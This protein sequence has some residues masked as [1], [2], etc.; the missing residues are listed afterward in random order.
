LI[1]RNG[2]EISRNS[3]S[4][5]AQLD[6]SGY[7]VSLYNQEHHQHNAQAMVT[8]LAAAAITTD[9][10]LTL[11]KGTASTPSFSTGTATSFCSPDYPVAVGGFSNANGVELLEAVS[12]PVWGTSSSL[13]LLGDVADGQTG[14]PTGWQ[15]KVI[16]NSIVAAGIISYGICGKAPA[17]QTF[18]YSVPVPQGVFRV[19]TPFSIFAPVPDGWTA[20]SSGFDGGRYG[21]YVDSDVWLQDG[22]M[23]GMLQWFESKGYDSAPRRSARS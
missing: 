1:D 13:V 15:V 14:A 11:V 20:V 21:T 3:L 10:T 17:L 7:S 8:C 6:S 23:V 22:I 19:A 4:S 9:N 2:V 12:A 16:N 18:V 5:L